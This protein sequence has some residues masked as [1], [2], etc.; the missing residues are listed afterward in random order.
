MHY[1][2]CGAVHRDDACDSSSSCDSVDED[3]ADDGFILFIQFDCPV[4]L[5]F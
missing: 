5:A 1:Q 3:F 2:V 4:C